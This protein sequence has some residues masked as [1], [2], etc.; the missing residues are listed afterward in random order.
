MSLL[1]LWTFP[2]VNR[3]YLIKCENISFQIVR[4]GA[5][6]RSCIVGIIC[7]HI[8]NF[9]HKTFQIEKF[10]WAP[11]RFFSQSILICISSLNNLIFYRE[12][13]FHTF[14]SC[15]SF[16][17]NLYILKYFFWQSKKEMGVNI[18]VQMKPGNGEVVSWWM[19][20]FC[21]SSHLGNIADE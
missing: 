12:G 18:R 5:K 21:L 3:I 9:C 16:V 17:Q 7:C 14:K 4:F 8:K 2:L 19:G 10:E 15:S 20:R 1:F 11:A 13:V 6:F